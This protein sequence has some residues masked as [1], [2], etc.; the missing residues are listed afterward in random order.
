MAGVF[1]TFLLNVI[2]L[3]KKENIFEKFASNFRFKCKTI[4]KEKEKKVVRS[5]WISNYFCPLNVYVGWK[6]VI[7]TTL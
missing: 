1:I 4:K 3:Q 6:C 5:L 2:V 7:S